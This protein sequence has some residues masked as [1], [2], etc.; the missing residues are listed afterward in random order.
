MGTIVPQKK[1]DVGGIFVEKVAFDLNVED[2]I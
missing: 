2:D 1:D